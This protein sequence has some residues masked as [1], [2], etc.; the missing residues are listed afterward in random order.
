MGSRL[1]TNNILS[2][3]LAFFTKALSVSKRLAKR[4]IAIVTAGYFHSAR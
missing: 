4:R 2:T 1:K 3:R